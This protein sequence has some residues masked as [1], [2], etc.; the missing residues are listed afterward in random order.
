[1]D[2][3]AAILGVSTLLAALA[4]TLPTRGRCACI[5]SARCATASDRRGRRD[6]A[7]SDVEDLA[8]SC[9][10]GPPVRHVGVD[11]PP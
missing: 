8:R 2:R 9:R 5:R 7:G 3:L 1:M 4:L 6:P 11:Q 10:S